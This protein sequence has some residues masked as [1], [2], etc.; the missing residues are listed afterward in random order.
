MGWVNINDPF[1]QQMLLWTTGTEEDGP[2]TTSPSCIFVKYAQ[3]RPA[4][5]DDVE[6]VVDDLE[7]NA[8]TPSTSE[9]PAVDPNGDVAAPRRR[10]R[11][12]AAV[13]GG[14]LNFIQSHQ[15]D[16]DDDE[17][18]LAYVPCV[19][20]LLKVG[21]LTSFENSK[22][23]FKISK[24]WFDSAD[25]MAMA[26]MESTSQKNVKITLPASTVELKQRDYLRKV[27]NCNSNVTIQLKLD[28]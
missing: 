23:E 1:V 7:S 2:D 19:N 9:N 17:V 10:K 6:S 24:L 11:E 18:H 20:G 3:F 16:D 8:E 13:Y 21:A 28:L 22:T 14:P 26:T 25:K 12:P 15:Q 4:P 5:D 27:S